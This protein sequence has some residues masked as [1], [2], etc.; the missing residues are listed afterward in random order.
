MPLPFA[1]RAARLGGAIDKA[2]GE[3]FTFLPFASSDDVDLPAIPDV[4]RLQFDV[5]GVWDEPAKVQIPHARGS[6]QDDNAHGWAASLPSVSVQDVLMP[7]RPRMRDRVRRL[8]DG[9]RYEISQPLPDGNGRTV[10][11]LTSK[12]IR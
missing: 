2:F 7:W 9:S 5:I 10:F 8:S 6:I 12:Q 4:S 11:M 3:S 1:S